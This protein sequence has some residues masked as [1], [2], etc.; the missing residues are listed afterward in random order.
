MGPSVSQRK[1][2]SRPRPR[3]R[4]GARERQIFSKESRKSGRSYSIPAF[5]FCFCHA[6]EILSIA[7]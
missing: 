4:G 3:T 7:W 2:G 1:V 5:F 6:S